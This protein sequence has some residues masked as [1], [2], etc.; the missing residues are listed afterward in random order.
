MLEPET[1]QTLQDICKGKVETDVSMAE[2]CSLKAGGRAAALAFPPGRE[3][4]EGLIAFLRKKRIPYLPFGR[5][6]N[7]LVREGG[8]PGVLIS[9]T[10]GF[11]KVEFERD[12]GEKL[13]R[14]RAEGGAPLA[15]VVE[16]AAQEGGAGLAALVGIPGSVGGAIRM[17]AGPAGSKGQIGG[18]VKTV[19]I[20][21]SSGRS[22]SRDREE[23][24]FGYRE[25]ALKER[26][27]VL[28]AVLEL[29]PGKPE[30][31]RKEME[32]LREKKKSTQPWDLPNAGSIFKNP[33]RNKAGQMIE[34]AG[35]KGVRIRGAQVSPMHANFIVNVGGATAKDILS[36]IGMIRDRVKEK[37]G[38][39]L[40]LELKVIGE[41]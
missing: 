21:E 28:E 12:E 38:V 20:L 35:L 23:L 4:L 29:A 15:R 6:T 2:Y 26:E 17:N 16:L 1:K 33:D 24:K 9:L 30:K 7:L 10:E 3:E 36:L 31:I 19:L 40:E 14:I 37:F 34:E 11:Q 32:T 8:Y 41:D 5:G 25:S 13:L 27:F 18:S 22:A 39:Q